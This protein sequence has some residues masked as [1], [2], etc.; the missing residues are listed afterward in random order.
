MMLGPLLDVWN[1]TRRPLPSIGMTVVSPFDAKLVPQNKN[2]R[3][4]QGKSVEQTLKLEN[5]PENGAIDL[6][7]LPR[8]VK[9][10]SLGRKGDQ[11]TIILE[12]AA[13]A[14]PGTFAISAAASGRKPA[15]FRAD[16]AHRTSAGTVEHVLTR[17]TSQNVLLLLLSA[18]LSSQDAAIPAK[19]T[20]QVPMRDGIHLAT[21]V[22]GAEPGVRKPVLLLRT[23]YDKNRSESTAL[24]QVAAGYVSVVQDARGAF[25]SEGHY[26]HHN[27][28]DQDGFDTLEWI[29]RQP[30]SNGRAGMWGSSH[31]GAVQWLAAAERSYGLEVLAPTAASPSL[32]R[33]AYLRRRAAVGADRRRRP[34]DRSA[35]A[36]AARRRRISLR[37]TSVSHSPTW[38]RRSDGRCHGFAVSSPIH[39]SMASGAASMPQAESRISTFRPST[40][41]ATTIFWRAKPWPVSSG[42]G[43]PPN[44]VGHA[45]TSN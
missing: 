35:A 10:R 1:F 24:R 25:A 7:D 13:D 27:N 3:V 45:P 15:R 6:F 40:S 37:Y 41:W 5:V 29:S 36:R 2:L 43:A 32:Y 18:T 8:G 17:I 16:R 12:A 39:A 30:W 21:D 20:F 11:E 44:R 28:D 19:Q 34:A 42:C 31:P 9:A 38:T 23:P 22:Y 26:I 14:E 4:E 33:T